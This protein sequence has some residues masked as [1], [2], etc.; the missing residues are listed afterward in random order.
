M[1]RKAE[2]MIDMIETE[3]VFKFEELMKYIKE[4]KDR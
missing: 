3:K 2:R 1:G 4:D